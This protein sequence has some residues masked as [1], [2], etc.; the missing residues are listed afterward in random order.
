MDKDV[1]AATGTVISYSRCSR[2]YH[3]VHDAA[4]GDDEN[5]APVQSVVVTGGLQVV[6]KQTTGQV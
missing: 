1:N 4:D 3:E 2:T 5:G 6:E